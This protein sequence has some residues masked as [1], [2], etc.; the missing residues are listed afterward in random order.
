ML[1]SLIPLLLV[2]GSHSDSVARDD[3]ISAVRRLSDPAGQ[4]DVEGKPHFDAAPAL[5]ITPAE[6]DYEAVLTLDTGDEIRIGLLDDAAP[7]HVN[8]FVFLANEGFFDG[9]M[10]FQVEPGQRVV[11]G[12]PTA[13]GNGGAGYTLPAEDS[14]TTSTLTLNEAGVVAMAQSGQGISS[15]Q[16]FVTLSAQPNLDRLGFTAFGK[17][18]AGLD[19]LQGLAA[20]DPAAVPTPPAGVRIQAV[21]IAERPQ[22][23]IGT[24]TGRTAEAFGIVEKP[25]YEAAP[26]LALESGVDYAAELQLAGGTVVIDLFEDTAPM[27]T[28]NFVFLAREGFYDGLTFHRV[29]PNFVAQGGDPTGTGTGGAGYLLPDEAPATDPSALTLDETGVIAMARGAQGASS[30]QFFITL[31]PQGFLDAQGFT[32]FGRVEEGLDV[33]QSIT[34]RDPDAAPTFVGDRII[35]VRI[36][37]R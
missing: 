10:I 33:V 24:E 20:R 3:T 15:S 37:E 9:L 30:S 12:D 14:P 11:S 35:A 18:L 28:N 5:A 36:I 8:N 16:F 13:S 23:V 31:A 26:A 29:L 34:V 22:G 19:V 17:V 21:R 4:T 32:T 1:G 2:G 7:T 6:L 27:H 25:Q